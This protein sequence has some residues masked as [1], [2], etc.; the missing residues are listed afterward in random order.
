MSEQE[1]PI[2]DNRSPVFR[3]LVHT[4]LFFFAPAA[5]AATFSENMIVRFI[6]TMGLVGT[7]LL[8]FLIRHDL[9]VNWDEVE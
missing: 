4:F 9:A 5:V 2:W 1:I 7:I 6:Q 3:A 8:G